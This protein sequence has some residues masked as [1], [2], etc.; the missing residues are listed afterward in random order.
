MIAAGAYL[1]TLRESQ[2]V[3]RSTLAE[4]LGTSETNIYRI[5]EEGQEPKGGLL[6]G[7]LNEVRGSG[8]DFLRLLFDTKADE[9]AGRELAQTRLTPAEFA[10]HEELKQLLGNERVAELTVRL[11]AEPDLVD[12]I[13]RLTGRGRDRR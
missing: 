4:R 10:R 8:A 13:D 11:M 6:L 9:V 1:R 7:F 3:S 2:E 5:E 12:A